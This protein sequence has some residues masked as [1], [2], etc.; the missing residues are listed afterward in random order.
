MILIARLSIV[1]AYSALNQRVR[2]GTLDRTTYA[3]LAADFDSTCTADYRLLDLHALVTKWAR[4]QLEQHSLRAHDV[5]QLATA[6]SATDELL[7]GWPAGARS[8]RHYDCRNRRGR[9]YRMRTQSSVPCR[10]LVKERIRRER[11]YASLHSCSGNLAA[12]RLRHGRHFVG[13]AH[14]ARGQPDH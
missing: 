8:G 1:E 11:F 2:E 10:P 6:L 13:H 5:V 4:L 14:G 3:T 9:L 7:A 12:P